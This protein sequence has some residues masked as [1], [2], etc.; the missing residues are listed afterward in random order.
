MRREP[1][2]PPM[3]YRSATWRPISSNSVG[4]YLVAKGPRV[5]VKDGVLG[6]LDELF[7]QP[8][9]PLALNQV[10]SKLFLTFPPSLPTVPRMQH[11]LE[12]N[13]WLHA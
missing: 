11:T 7:Q 1:P 2:I 9:Y 6:V 13:F 3:Q 10:V 5:E 4:A 8:S 12:G